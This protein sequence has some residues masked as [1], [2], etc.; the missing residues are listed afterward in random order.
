[1]DQQ[2]RDFWE[3]RKNAAERN[4]RIAMLEARVQELESPGYRPA[5]APN[6]VELGLRERSVLLALR[7]APGGR[8]FEALRLGGF[9]T[10]PGLTAYQRRRALNTTLTALELLGWTFKSG[11]LYR[12]TPE[13]RQ[14]TKGLA[15]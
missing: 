2:L 15:A 13:G 4:E 6:V 10:E 3:N 1:M 8:T 9:E 11:Y 12:L 14:L 5:Q 7:T